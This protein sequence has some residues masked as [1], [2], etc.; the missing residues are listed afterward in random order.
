[1]PRSRATRVF[2]A[3]TVLALALTCD[4][5]S[6]QKATVDG[7]VKGRRLQTALQ[8][9]EEAR[10]YLRIAASRSAED[11]RTTARQAAQDVD[12]A[13]AALN[14]ALDEAKIARTVPRGEAAAG[15]DRPFAAAQKALTRASNQ[16]RDVDENYRAAAKEPLERIRLATQTVRSAARNEPA[17]ATGGSTGD[18]DTATADQRRRDREADRAEANRDRAETSSDASLASLP[19]PVQQTVRQNAPNLQ[20]REVK[21]EGEGGGEKGIVYRIEGTA[22]GRKVEMQVAENGDLLKMERKD[23]EGN[24]GKGKAK[25]KDKDK[26]KD[27]GR[28]KDKN[29]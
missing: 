17:I 25:G 4:T 11:R 24:E 19:A 6:A 27:K 14:Q 10:D 13:I 1:M 21:R 7:D 29:D 5:A 22:D 12:S 3:L 15:V 16:L 28:G 9:L 2:T 23:G 20:V 26:D 8:S 18:D